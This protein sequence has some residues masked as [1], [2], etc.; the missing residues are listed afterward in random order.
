MNNQRLLNES[1]RVFL[2]FFLKQRSN[3]VTFVSKGGDVMTRI[4]SIVDYYKTSLKDGKHSIS[5]VQECLNRLKTYQEKKKFL[6]IIEK[7][8]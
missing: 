4:N 1:S 2:F 3:V 8:S 6:A 5:T 7:E